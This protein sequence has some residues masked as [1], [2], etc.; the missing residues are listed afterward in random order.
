MAGLA[1][2]A[3]GVPLRVI[4]C[5]S[6]DLVNSWHV[7][8]ALQG[9]DPQADTIIHGGARGADALADYYARKMGFTVETFPAEWDKYGKRAGYVRNRAM[10]DSGA[11][12][13]YAFVSKPIEESRGTA[14]MVKIAQEAGVAVD[15]YRS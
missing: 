14:M 6:R 5:G 12:H 3:Q 13:V 1:A 2:S 10:L 7:W 4:F 15:I 8:S 9:L 11:D